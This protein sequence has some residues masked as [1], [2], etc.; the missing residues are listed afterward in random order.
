MKAL[1]RRIQRYRRGVELPRCRIAPK[2]AV[3]GAWWRSVMCLYR[4]DSLQLLDSLQVDLRTVPRLRHEGNLILRHI[5]HR[6][7]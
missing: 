1:D 5:E 7:K 4:P 6:E 2:H 3:I